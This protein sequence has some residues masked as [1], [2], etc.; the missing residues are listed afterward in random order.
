P[1]PASCCTYIPQCLLR[2]HRFHF[3]P[4]LLRRPRCSTLCPY[5]TLFRSFD[6]ATITHKYADTALVV[7]ARGEDGSERR[8]TV[9]PEQLRPIED[10]KSTRLNSSHV[11]NSYAVFCLKKQIR[12]RL[13]AK[14][15]SDG[16]AADWQ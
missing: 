3:V 7:T 14:T 15:K 13:A 5:T 8:G 4:H 12:S 16:P 6:V 1:S 9:H 11:S 2:P 10:R